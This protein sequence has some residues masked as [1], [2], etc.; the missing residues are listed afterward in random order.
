MKLSLLAMLLLVSLLGCQ[1]DETP[2]KLVKMMPSHTIN[3][4]QKQEPDINLEDDKKEPEKDPKEDDNQTE[5]GQEPDEETEN[6]TQVPEATAVNVVVNKQRKL[7]NNFVPP[8]LVVPN[9]PFSFDSWNEKKQVR[10]ITATALEEL[11]AGAAEAG[12]NLYAVS[13]YRSYER[14]KSIYNWNVQNS[15]LE[16]ANKYSAKPGHSE[17]QTGLAMD[18]SSSAV[19]YNL[20]EAFGDTEEGKW[21]EKNAHEY[22]F[23]IRYP[24]GKSNITG[25]NYEPWHLRFI[26][27]EAAKEIYEK[28][29]TIEEYFDFHEAT[30]PVNQE[31]VEENQEN[32]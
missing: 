26:G 32:H 10:Q 31:S 2:N 30:E 17:H 8:N 27:K 22:G 24:E 11:F 14:Q 15:G 6:I 23:V 9:V 21:V 1:S 3:P 19:G 4:E 28:D 29:I 5:N 18:V 13:G 12:I 7:P 20:V 16:H 25:Y